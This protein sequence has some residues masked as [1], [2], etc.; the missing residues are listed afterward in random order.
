MPMIRYLLRT[1]VD[2]DLGD[3]AVPGDAGEFVVLADNRD[4]TYVVEGALWPDRTRPRVDIDVYDMSPLS[5]PKSV[6]R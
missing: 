1:K 2:L 6:I 4:G 5:G 3:V